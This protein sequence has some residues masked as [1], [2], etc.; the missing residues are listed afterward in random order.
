MGGAPSLLATA[1]LRETRIVKQVGE[2]RFR[3]CRRAVRTT[4]AENASGGQHEKA[5]WLGNGPEPRAAVRD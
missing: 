5:A 1:W 4:S 2:H 3:E